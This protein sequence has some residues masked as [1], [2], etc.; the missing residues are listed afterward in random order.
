MR[1]T[2][3]QTAAVLRKNGFRIRP[4]KELAAETFSSKFVQKSAA[5]IWCVRPCHAHEFVAVAQATQ[6]TAVSV[7]RALR[8]A[9][10]VAAPAPPVSLVQPCCAAFPNSVALNRFVPLRACLPGSR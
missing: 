3:S 4:K 10:N 8:I 7:C 5:Q 9:R 1:Q 2:D 6:Q